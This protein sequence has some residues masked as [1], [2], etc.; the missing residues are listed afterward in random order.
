[1]GVFKVLAAAA[2]LLAVVAP[3]V[4]A[5]TC[6]VGLK[7]FTPK[8]VRAGRKFTARAVIKNQGVNGLTNFY[9][10]LAVPD[11]MT[12]M[13]DTARASFPAKRGSSRPFV[14]GRFIHFPAMRLPPRKTLRIKVKVGVPTCQAGG[15]VQFSGIAYS[16][17]DA[18]GL[19]CTSTTEAGSDVVHTSKRLNA[20]HA[21]VGN[22]TAP[23]AP[24]EGYGLIGANMRCLQAVPLENFPADGRRSLTEMA[25]RRGLL[26]PLASPAE[27][28]CWACCGAHLNAA[29]SYFFN[30]AADGQ[31]YC[32]AKCDPLYAPAWTVSTPTWCV[33]VR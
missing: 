11:Y 21:V 8:T 7:L 1:M 18:G 27:L 2:T 33:C 10:Q 30:L 9:F 23:P 20:R 25:D 16:L 13:L 24:E 32:C 12:P 22:C 28:Q 3:A 26:N 15:R 19:V 5:D 17:D 6:N 4:W 29:G 14:Q 31:C